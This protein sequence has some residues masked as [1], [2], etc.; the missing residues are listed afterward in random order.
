MFTQSS[1]HLKFSWSEIK[2]TGVNLEYH[3]SIHSKSLRTQNFLVEIC[4]IP[5]VNDLLE[6]PLQNET[7][8][9]EIMH[10]QVGQNEF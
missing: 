3:I 7:S 8:E 4:M 1:V 9:D 2:Y 10:D 5:S 6:Q